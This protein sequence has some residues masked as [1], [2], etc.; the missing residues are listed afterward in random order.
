[1]ELDEEA[2]SS[3]EEG[4]PAWMAT[5]SDMATLLLTFFVLMLSFANMDVRN[6]K[7]AMGSVRNAMGVQ[8]KINGDLEGLTTSLLELSPVQS[9]DYIPLDDLIR[10]AADEVKQYVKGHGFEGAVEVEA[11]PMGV[12]LRA[13]NSVL[14]ETGSDEL[15]VEGAPILDL[16]ADLFRRFV[17]D[18]SIQGHTDSVPIRSARFPSNWEL[19]TSR[20]TAVLRYLRDEREVDVA[21]LHVAGYADTRPIAEGDSD[22]ARGRNR[23]VEF[24]FLFPLRDGR[25]D[26]HEAFDL[27]GNPPAPPSPAVQ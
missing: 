6:F 7:Q 10:R 23:R 8:F 20:A 22:E 19:S 24:Q 14:F 21:R 9:G 17:G 27:P 2:E 3:C 4:S 1:M 16:I 13:R 18:L 5:F 25:V 12:V 26:A 15:L 11:S